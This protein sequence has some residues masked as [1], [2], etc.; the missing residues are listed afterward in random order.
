MDDFAKLPSEERQTYFEQAA[1]QR[2]LT[3]Q[4]IE[5]DFWVCWSLRRLFSLSEFRDHLTFKGGT[6]LSKV[7]QAIERFSE[8][9]DVAI[10]RSFLG[11]GGDNEPETGGS[12]QQQPRRI[13]ALKEAC[14][15]AVADRMMPQLKEAVAGA[16]GND[17]TWTLSLDPADP[18]RQSLLFRYPPAI[19][20][21]LSPYFAA[22]VKFEFGARSDHFPIEKGSITPYIAD[23]LADAI[24]DKETQ[25]RVLSA[26]RTFWEKAT[27]LHMLYH[28]PA[29]KRVAPRMSRHYYDLFGLAQSDV[30]DQALATL[31]LLDRVADF[32]QV[33]FKAGW[34]KYDEA[35]PGT[36]RLMPNEQLS[37]LLAGDYE[38]MQPMFFSDPPPFQQILDLLPTLENRINEHGQ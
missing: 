27:I 34:A 1:A 26:A 2:G 20:S 10:E 9:V 6:S 37:N 33:Y 7:Y 18:D 23:E 17:S 11:F 22:S 28:Q 35:R 31:D 19:S 13:A 29:G 24:S 36:L 3:A 8:D 16:L 21:G 25:V 15:V 30:L 38:D 12:G 14:Q 4:V 5:K 32:K